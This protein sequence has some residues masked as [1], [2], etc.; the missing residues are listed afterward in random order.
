MKFKQLFFASAIAMTGTGVFAQDMSVGLGLTNFGLS[1]QGDYA[2]QPKLHVRGM[3][4]GGFEFTDTFEQEDYTVD[5]KVTLGG[6]AA[7]ADFYPLAGAW[8]ISGGVLF[9]S[10]ELTGDFVG[11]EN[12]TGSAALKEDVAPMVTTGFSASLP[13]GVSIYGDA[14]VVLSAIE[15][16]S[17][18]VDPT[19]QDEITTLN[20]DLSD[21]PVFPFI[22]VGLSYSF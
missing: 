19:V 6:A 22:G 3:V 10:S 12:F 16:S 13:G 20:N 15:V 7:I 18:S 2:I 8:R 21:V 11:A 5:G 17:D 1:L 4:M 14:G 9:S